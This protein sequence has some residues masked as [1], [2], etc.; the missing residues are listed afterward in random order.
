VTH[1]SHDNGLDRR[2]L[3][4][5]GSLL[6]GAGAASAGVAGL[7]AAPAAAHPKKTVRYD[8]ACLGDTFRIILHPDANPQAG[9]LRGSTFSVEGWIYPAGT[10]T[11]TGFDPAS[12][13]SIGR[14]FCRGWFLINPDRLE[15]H[16][17]TTQEYV[18][19]EIRPNRLFPRN[20]LASS[21]IEGTFEEQTAI[22]SVIGGTGNFGGATGE[23][24]QHPRGTNTT[25]IVPLGIDAPNFRFEFR[26]RIPNL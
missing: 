19:G 22:R 23:V 20:T 18:F 13:E 4:K 1:E 16:V 3:L 5:R 10:I 25:R 6:A 8:V 14:W 15:P 11:G 21:G 12:A 7:A 9:E 2:T 24:L 17:I 26:L